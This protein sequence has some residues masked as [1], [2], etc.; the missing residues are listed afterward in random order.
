MGRG[1]GVYLGADPDELFSFE[2]AGTVLSEADIDEW[3]QEA[4]ALIQ[5]MGFE[6]AENSVAVSAAP[7][8]VSGGG[9][10]L[11]A[12]VAGSREDRRE[13]GLVGC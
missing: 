10:G 1:N 12:D 11:V 9:G 3:V 4:R 7:A 5:A 6:G 8:A 2:A 13:G